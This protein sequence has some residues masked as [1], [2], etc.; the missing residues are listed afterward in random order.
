MTS[1]LQ[2]QHLERRPALHVATSVRAAGVVAVNEVLQDLVDVGQPVEP[3][4]VEGHPVALVQ[5]RAVEPLDHRVVVGRARRDPAMCDP[6]RLRG[7]P[8]A[9]GGARRDAAGGRALAE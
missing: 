1:S 6:D 9:S 8:D 5:D 7:G 3:T 4:P 2:L